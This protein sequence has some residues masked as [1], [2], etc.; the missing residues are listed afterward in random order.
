[1]INIK[2]V[3]LA[4]AG[5]FLVIAPAHISALGIDNPPSQNQMAPNKFAK[6]NLSDSDITKEIKNELKSD[7]DFAAKTPNIDIKT[8]RGIVT[9]SGTVDNQAMKNDIETI[10]KNIAGDNNVIDTIIVKAS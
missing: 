3:I 6:A 2:H 8:E 4:S 7:K 10:A 5:L 1:M 9:L